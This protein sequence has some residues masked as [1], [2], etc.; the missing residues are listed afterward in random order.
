MDENTKIVSVDGYLIRNT[1]DDDFH[2]LHVHPTEKAFFADHKLYIPR[3]EVWVDFRYEKETDFLLSVQF[4]LE[5]NEHGIPQHTPYLKLREIMKDKLCTKGPVPDF[6]LNE[7]TEG[8]NKIVGVDGSIVRQFIDPEF[9]AGGHYLVYA[10]IPEGEIWY[11]V[12]IDE[13]EVEAVTL[14]EKIEVGLM[15]EGKNY[16][17]AHEYARAHEREKRREEGGTYPGDFNYPW[18]GQ[19]LEAIIKNYYVVKS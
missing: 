8:A 19:S 9:F 16:D 5:R 10:Y 2:V 11:D 12:F 17:V 6:R 13:R 14:H 7:K 18:H 3:D 4:F 15:K 1:M